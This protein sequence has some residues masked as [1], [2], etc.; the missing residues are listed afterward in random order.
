[1]EHIIFWLMLMMLMLG[2]NIGTINENIET[3]IAAS[4]EVDL[5]MNVEKTKYI[6]LSRH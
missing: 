6:L 5:E 3:I 4:K 2:D 1:M